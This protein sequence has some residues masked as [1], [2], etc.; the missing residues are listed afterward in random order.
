MVEHTRPEGYIGS[1]DGVDWESWNR[2]VRW[3]D[4]LD[5]EVVDATTRG[6]A[7]GN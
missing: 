2:W 5:V 7:L 4:D 3:K 1:D 6:D